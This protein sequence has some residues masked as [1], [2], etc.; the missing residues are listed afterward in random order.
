MEMSQR[1]ETKTESKVGRKQQLTMSIICW[2]LAHRF[3]LYQ[4]QFKL[5]FKTAA[6]NTRKDIK[7]ECFYAS[8]C[9]D[10]FYLVD[11][12]TAPS[13]ISAGNRYLDV[14]YTCFHKVWML[15]S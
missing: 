13:C 7:A 11:F 9:T 3:G 12:L 15:V 8:E 2:L 14:F 6:V 5:K 4:A 10:Y 1:R